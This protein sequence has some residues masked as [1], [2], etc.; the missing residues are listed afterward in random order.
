MLDDL[1]EAFTV[2]LF[3]ILDLA[4]DITRC[5]TFPDHRCRRGWQVPVRRSR[6]HIQ[7]GNVLFLMTRTALLTVFPLTVSPPSHVLHVNVA[8]VTLTWKVA[9][10][11]AIKTPRMFQN[12]DRREKCFASARV[13][14]L[15]RRIGIEGEA[16]SRSL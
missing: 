1:R 6:R 13:V 12:R 14:P 16:S 10:R 3:R 5:P 7:S 2:I 15:D 8:I 11:M 4:T 9:G